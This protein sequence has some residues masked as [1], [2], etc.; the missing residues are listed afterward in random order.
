MPLEEEDEEDEEDA[1][2]GRQRRTDGVVRT[3]LSVHAERRREATGRTCG[4]GRQQIRT[5]LGLAAADA[6]PTMK[7]ALRLGIVV[8]TAFLLLVVLWSRWARGRRRFDAFNGEPVVLCDTR[9][10][11]FASPDISFDCPPQSQPSSCAAALCFAPQK[12][13]PAPHR[14]VH[15]A[16]ARG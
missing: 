4:S 13:R 11:A 15:G 7:A 16:G 3:G 12:M 2:K 14:H 8:A 5:T 1:G 9:G 6:G 10:Y